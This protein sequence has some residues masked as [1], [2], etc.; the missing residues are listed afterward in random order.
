MKSEI[1][2]DLCSDVILLFTTHSTL[3]CSRQLMEAV[4]RSRDTPGAK[5]D[6]RRTLVLRSVTV[7][8]L[9]L[10]IIPNIS[11]TSK[12]CLQLMRVMISIKGNPYGERKN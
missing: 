9:V 5:W 1:K 10:A 4:T 7:E 2:A 8:R 12:V 3:C 6:T 11:L